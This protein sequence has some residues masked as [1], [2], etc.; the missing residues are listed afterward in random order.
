MRLARSLPFRRAAPGVRGAAAPVRE[1]NL[2]IRD[3]VLVYPDIQVHQL[4]E[5]AVA[6]DD[7]GRPG[8]RVAL[9]ASQSVGGAPC[10]D[11][12]GAA[13][14]VLC[15][16][17]IRQKFGSQRNDLASGLGRGSGGAR[18]S[19]HISSDHVCGILRLIAQGFLHSVIVMLRSNELS[20][21]R[22]SL[23]LPPFPRRVSAPASTAP[24]EVT[25]IPRPFLPLVE[26]PTATDPADQAAPDFRFRQRLVYG[27]RRGDHAGGE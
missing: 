12:A 21:W 10:P 19:R 13:S 9:A 11:P 8:R 3:G 16:G 15:G 6:D 4:V 18:A 1:L 26:E 20:E 27:D 25:G 7:P 14:A 2:P 22:R 23:G 17:T 5:D 24:E